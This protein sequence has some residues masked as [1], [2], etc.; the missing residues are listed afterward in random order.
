MMLHGVAAGT[1]LRLHQV[2]MTQLYLAS[3][4]GIALAASIGAVDRF[5]NGPDST[6]VLAWIGTGTCSL[7]LLGIALELLWQRS[8]SASIIPLLDWLHQHSVPDR[9]THIAVQVLSICSVGIASVNMH[10]EIWDWQFGLSCTLLAMVFLYNVF[11]TPATIVSIALYKYQTPAQRRSLEEQ[12]NGC[13]FIW[14]N[15]HIDDRLLPSTT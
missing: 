2:R 14:K 12:V 15:S 13:T 1:Q 3:W 9:L 7:M 11:Y 10:L 6:V 8:G 4:V 5:T